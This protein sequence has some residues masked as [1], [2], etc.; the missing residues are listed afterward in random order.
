M[1]NFDV[2]G[3]ASQA[4]IAYKIKK[5]DINAIDVNLFA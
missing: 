4:F 5:L 2:F 3:T 1:A